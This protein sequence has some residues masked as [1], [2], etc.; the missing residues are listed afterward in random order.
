[1]SMKKLIWGLTYFD[2][3]VLSMSSLKT[4]YHNIRAA[5]GVKSPHLELQYALEKVKEFESNP[6]V[7]PLQ[8][9]IGLYMHMVG[10]MSLYIR[11]VR[12]GNNCALCLSALEDC[13]VLFRS[14]QAQ[15]CQ[16]DPIFLA[17]MSQIIRTRNIVTISSGNWV[18]NK[19]TPSTFVL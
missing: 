5:N 16:D 8:K 2:Q 18:V 13:Q 3:F 11:A 12:T 7:K 6:Q 1:M 19:K 9:A 4:T 15:L 17:E 10:A 14:G